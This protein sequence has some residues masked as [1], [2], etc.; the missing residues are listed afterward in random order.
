MSFLKKIVTSPHGVLDLKLESNIVS[1]GEAVRGALIFSSKDDFVSD[2]VRCEIEC[3]E[4]FQNMQMV[5]N[6]QQQMVGKNLVNVSL[7]KNSPW[8]L[9]VT[10]RK[11][12][13]TIQQLNLLYRRAEYKLRVIKPHNI[14]NFI[15][16]IACFY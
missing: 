13:N 11:K 9:I 2:M 16:L 5:E 3:S 6:M 4:L 7:T 12:L 1:R 15:F 10:T 14:Q 8:K